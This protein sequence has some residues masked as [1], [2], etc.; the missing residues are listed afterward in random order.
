M[1]ILD[2]QG[3]RRLPVRR[4]NGV[5]VL[6]VGGH[7]SLPLQS[8]VIVA[9]PVVA[10]LLQRGDLV[11]PAIVRR[12]RQARSDRLLAP[13]KSLQLAAGGDG[14]VLLCG[15]VEVEDNALH[16]AVVGHGA[17]VQI[18]PFLRD[19]HAHRRLVFH[20]VPAGS[21]DLV[22]GV[23]ARQL[24]LQDGIGDIAAVRSPCG[25]INE[26][27]VVKGRLARQGDSQ[28]VSL[29]V[30]YGRWL[31]SVDRLI[32][33]DYDGVDIGGPFMGIVHRPGDGDRHRHQLAVVGHNHGVV[34]GGEIHRRF[35]GGYPVRNA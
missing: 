7:G 21:A 2:G 31:A 30:G 4:D 29:I 12:E 22:G 10:L 18:V 9:L 17:A 15:A 6:V 35:S 32:Q 13:Q 33:G 27:G 1:G 28:A 23:I 19:G 3:A 16:S 14:R 34:A 24:I 20:D 11:C 8:E 25:Q 5:A 26:G